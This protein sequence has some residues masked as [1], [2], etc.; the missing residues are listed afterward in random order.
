MKKIAEINKKEIA[1]VCGGAEVAFS[2]YAITFAHEAAKG[3]LDC[4]NKGKYK[5]QSFVSC[6]VNA[7]Y[8][9]FMGCLRKLG[10]FYIIEP[11]TKK[12]KTAM[13]KEKISE[14]KKEL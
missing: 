7:V 6:G 10:D 5:L 1:C 8:S 9:G 3:Y 13:E 4:I 12:I 14:E 11:M 2:D